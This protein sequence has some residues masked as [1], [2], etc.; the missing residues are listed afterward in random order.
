MKGHERKPRKLGTG[1]ASE[2]PWSAWSV[3][4]TAAL[5]LAAGALVWLSTTGRLAEW[6]R[7]F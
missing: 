3:A 4:L 5:F 7:T 6:W 1:G 2:L